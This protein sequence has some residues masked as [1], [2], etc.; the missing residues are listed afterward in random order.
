M[1]LYMR[2]KYKKF[3]IKTTKTITN[4]ELIHSH[5]TFGVFFSGT[6]MAELNDNC[7]GH[8]FYL[9]LI[10]NNA[11]D[12]IAKIA[13]V[14]SVE[15]EV[16]QVPYYANTNLGKRFIIEKKT[17]TLKKDK[18]FTYDCDILSP[19]IPVI[20]VG[21]DFASKVAEIMKPKPAPKP[22]YTPPTT[23]PYTPNYPKP[24]PVIPSSINNNLDQ[25]K[26]ANKIKH[27]KL[28]DAKLSPRAKKVKN[29]VKK[30]PFEDFEDLSD[31]FDFSPLEKFTME[32]MKFTTPLDSTENLEDILVD[33]ED[34][35]LDAYTIASGV[36]ENYT[37]LYD[38]HF[39]DSTD[40][41][42]IR[43]TDAV[44][45]ILSDEVEAYP[46]IN[47]AIEAIKAMIAEFEKDGS[48]V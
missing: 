5:N 15:Q 20:A 17:F 10:V 16:K 22:A 47:V 13:F 33:L 28:D 43:D 37:A 30:L 29:L 24:T 3:S 48:T 42:F 35:N 41:E 31:A 19:E 14:G 34:L 7:G 36:M 2:Q 27:F 1:T 23:N 45:G 21:E 9:S 6:D 11:L 26:L 39:P 8:N 44:V 46:F 4:W 25:A 12:F 32:L 38:K 18:M 40:D